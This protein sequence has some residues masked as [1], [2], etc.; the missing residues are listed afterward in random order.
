MKIDF[1][2]IPEYVRNACNGA[3]IQ[4]GELRNCAVRM[5]SYASNHVQNRH[6]AI[7]AMALTCLA[8]CEFSVRVVRVAGRGY[9][10]AFGKYGDLSSSQQNRLALGLAAM[11][12][13]TYSAT[14]Y[15]IYKALCMPLTPWEAI[16]ISVGSAVLFFF[17]RIGKE[18]C[19]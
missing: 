14:N 13:L 17:A 18:C 4:I 8:S 10:A 19:C 9:K 7:A 12:T 16:A 3:S 11:T 5:M 6:Y 2:L 1:N 15:A